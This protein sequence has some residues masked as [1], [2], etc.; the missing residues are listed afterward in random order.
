MLLLDVF[1]NVIQKSV[2]F[3][4]KLRDPSLQLPGRA[5]LS[6]RF[7]LVH[8]FLVPLLCVSQI[9]LPYGELP[10]HL[11][12]VWRELLLQGLDTQVLRG[13]WKRVLRV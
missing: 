12:Y 4:L 9:L 10:L 6:L 3:V 11:Y 7:K 13:H 2:L 8:Q 1:L 5:L